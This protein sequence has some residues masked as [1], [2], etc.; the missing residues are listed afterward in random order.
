MC[1]SDLSGN[2]IKNSSFE[3]DAKVGITPLFWTIPTWKFKV[4]TTD[5][6]KFSGDYS[7]NISSNIVSSNGRNFYVC[8]EVN[9]E[10]YYT[11]HYGIKILKNDNTENPAGVT[12]KDTN[13]VWNENWVQKVSVSTF[14]VSNS[15]SWQEVKNFI[16]IPLGITKLN[17]YVVVRNQKVLG[18]CNVYFDDIYF[19]K[20]NIPPVYVSDLTATVEH[21]KVLLHWTAPGNDG[22]ENLLLYNSCYIIKFT[23]ETQKVNE[24]IFS[25]NNPNII[26]STFNVIPNSIQCLVLNGLDLVENTTYYFC[27]WTKDNSDNFS[28]VSNVANIFYN[29]I[30]D[31][32]KEK[33]EVSS[34]SIKW[35]IKDNSLSE[36]G[37]YISSNQDMNCRLSENLGPLEN[38]GSLVFW[39]EKNLQPNS[40]YLRYVET[41]KNNVSYW[42]EPFTICTEAVP[43]KKFNGELVIYGSSVSFKISWDTSSLAEGYI[44]EYSTTQNVWI[45][46]G[47]LNSVTTEFLHL[48]LIPEVTYY[49]RILPFNKFGKIN[50]E[51]FCQLEILSP[52]DKIK[53]FYGIALTTTSIMWC[54]EANPKSWGYRI[55]CSTSNKLITTISKN[56]TYYIENFLQPNVQYNR[57]I[58]G[59]NQQ[60]GLKS[61]FSKVCT[62]PNIPI[63][64]EIENL[65]F[66]KVTISFNT[67]NNPE[68]TIYDVVYSTD[69]KFIYNKT[70]ILTQSP[71]MIDFE[72]TLENLI[73]STT[74]WLK[75]RAINFDGVYSMFSDILCIS[76]L[77]IKSPIITQFA[78]RGINSA[79]DEFVELWNCS[80]E[81]IDISSFTLEYWDGNSWVKKVVIPENTIIK[82]YSF[83]LIS[84]SSEYFKDNTSD[85]YHKSYLNIT[86]GVLGEPRGIRLVSRYSSVVDKIIYEGNG[87]TFNEQA[88]GSLTAP[89]CGNKPNSNSVTR[90]KDQLS[91]Y[92]DTDNNYNDFEIL[93]R[94]PRSS[95]NL[96]IEKN[97]ENVIFPV[98][99]IS[100]ETNNKTLNLKWKNLSKNIDGYLIYISTYH[101]SELSYN[102]FLTTVSPEINEFVITNLKNHINY[103]I[104]VVSFIEKNYEIK[105]SSVFYVVSVTPHFAPPK[106]LKYKLSS[107]KI[108]LSW[109]Y[110]VN[111]DISG[112]KIYYSTDESQFNF[113][114]FTTSCYYE[115]YDLS[116][117]EK[118][119]YVKVVDKY[120]EESLP[121]DILFVKTDIIPPKLI[122]IEEIILEKNNE[123]KI[124]SKFQDDRF[125][126]GDQRGFLKMLCGKFKY[127]DD[128]NFYDVVV[129]TISYNDGFFEGYLVIKISNVTQKN[130]GL[131]Y[132]LEF[133]DGV[134]FKRYPENGY[135][136]IVFVSSSSY[137]TN[138]NYT[139]TNTNNYVESNNKN[140]YI[141]PTKQ[142]VV[143][144]NVRELSIYTINR[145]R[146]W[147][148]SDNEK[149][150]LVWKAQD[151]KGNKVSSGIYF[152]EYKTK[153]GN[154]KVGII[155]VVK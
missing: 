65:S 78:T 57:Y 148:K 8:Q 24:I 125:V 109:E 143:F 106:D 26:I 17:F 81:D 20:D 44:L 72:F 53:N 101:F 84:S 70:I 90:K 73:P 34:C 108:Y 113:I 45:N 13:L 48:N 16:T 82:P 77:K 71:N 134:N 83:Y 31:W 122:Y 86:D 27:I 51:N 28:S 117:Y 136:N 119:Y 140:Y 124:K 147:H 64:L 97:E 49:Y 92:I 146:I 131:S 99:I 149:D 88:E 129:N 93:P 116:N 107:E 41:E 15:I 155:I 120:Y 18:S 89:S 132:Y 87:A 4:V 66:D 112:Y 150:V 40:L 103:F 39:E 52:I 137:D 133:S 38:K 75:I 11:Y 30:A 104:T 22:I 61:Q 135:K 98:E 19:I 130:A 151:D 91:Y 58:V 10:P 37:I 21:D 115:D 153:N 102:I 141:T 111:D 5:Q 139:D 60:E 144:N 33:I 25:T 9:V 3:E 94:Q 154:K 63:N 145:E 118:Y 35:A 95:K 100:V 46:L 80:N 32:E 2:L 127:L 59:F 152:Y 12:I 7:L 105:T 62:L 85:F 55:Y 74:Y 50:K 126:E 6:E 23:T 54:W 14:T 36:S 47:K 69:K 42:N 67:N 121:S 56:L 123:I 1:I 68:G 142:E 43:P 128:T 110:N 138:N 76:T 96:L 79:Y 114:A 29:T